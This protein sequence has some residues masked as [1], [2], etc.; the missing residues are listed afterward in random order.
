[1]SS[2]R[3]LV[4]EDDSDTR[5][6]IAE[7]LVDMGF[8]VNVAANGLDGMKEAEKDGHDLII[9]DWKLP[10]LEGIEICRRLRAAGMQTPIILLTGKNEEL[11]RVLGLELGA[12]DYLGKPFSVREL[13]ARVKARLRGAFR[14]ESLSIPADPVLRHGSL[15]LDRDRREVIRDGEKLD[16]TAREFEVLDFFMRHP[17]RVFTREQLLEHVWGYQ[18]DGYERVVSTFISRIRKKIERDAEN[19]EVLLTVHGVGYKFSAQNA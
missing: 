5:K 10:G 13:G 7:S 8:S 17:D 1:M 18:S 11:D 12:D 9:L 3:I 4:I 19:P 2:S 14:S 6:L 15:T 16:L